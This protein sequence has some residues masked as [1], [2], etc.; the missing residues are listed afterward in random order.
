MNIIDDKGR[1][2]GT[3][4]IIDAL[5]VLLVF[6]VVAGGTAFV[7]GTDD[8]ST[9]T[10]QQTTTV[11]PD[12]STDQQTTTVTLDIT[13]VQPYVAD[14]IP[15][16]RISSDDVAIVENKSVRPAEV[17]V[18]DQDGQLHE[19]TH[20]RKKTVTLELTLN[21]TETDDELLFRDEP[22]EVGREL[23]LDLGRVTVDG[24]VTE[25]PNEG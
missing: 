23:T 16:G 12:T 25:F 18:E 22:L 9:S 19:Q 15:E 3:I 4:N 21:T 10:D 1:L 7:L 20:P 11:T 2:F 14:A 24:T 17:I 5:V 13:H 6:A 8:Q